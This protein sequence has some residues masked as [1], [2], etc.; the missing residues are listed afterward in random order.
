MERAQPWGQ[1]CLWFLLADEEPGRV[2]EPLGSSVKRGGWSYLWQWLR[3]YLQLRK[4]VG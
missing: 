1:A 2:A 3:A 4:E